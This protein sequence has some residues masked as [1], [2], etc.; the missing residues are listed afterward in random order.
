MPT[1]N[2][3]HIARIEGHGNVEVEL[4]DGAVGR[5]EL[6]TVEPARF[7]EAMVGGRHFNDVALI[8]S[9]IC[10][11]C[12]PN[13]TVTGLMAVEAALGLEVSER[14]KLLRQLLVNGSF[15]Q[16]FATHL[17][18]LAAPD[19]L[20]LPS[21]LPL[22]ESKPEVLTRALGLKRLGND[23]CTIVGGR[24]VHPINAVVGGFTD[25]PDAETLKVLAARLRE[26][27]PD[28]VLTVK[29]LASFEA[30]DFH[31]D[32]EMLAL[33]KAGTYATVADGSD[34][35]VAA[36]KAAWR[37]PVA[38]YPDFIIERIEP[39]KGNAKL[40]SVKDAVGAHLP[41]MVGALARVNLSFDELLPSARAVAQD[42]GLRKGEDNPYRNNL[43]QAIE[44]VDALERC[45]VFCDELARGEGSSTPPRSIALCAGTGRAATEAPRGTLYHTISLDEQGQV[46][47]G[48]V[49]TPTAQNLACIE[50]DLRELAPLLNGRAQDEQILCIEQLI[51]AYDPCLSCAVH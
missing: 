36:R 17:Y 20:G 32:R 24:P 49:I 45:A 25:E 1:L 31:P 12:S 21:A 28:A 40:S 29:L 14:T 37:K 15:V 19:Y 5:V 41:F 7:F 42:A 2:I 18:V 43:C 16:N 3:H 48:D 4:R 44:L 33:Y 13:H 6:K 34:C 46:S 23:L 22:A 11:I 27:L 38:D 50:A 30:P 51:R 39:A 47:G 35:Q 8:V 10:G 26:A 9:R